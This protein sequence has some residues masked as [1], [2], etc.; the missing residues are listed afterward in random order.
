MNLVKLTKEKTGT[1]PKTN[2]I[3][4][5]EKLGH[6]RANIFFIY[7]AVFFNL[8]SANSVQGSVIILKLA[9]F[10]VSRFRHKFNN[11]SKVPRLEKG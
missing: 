6:F 4:N 7:K 10:L 11:V 8:G 9:L 3:R 2:V 5:N 1:S